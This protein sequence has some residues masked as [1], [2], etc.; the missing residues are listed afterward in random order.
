L[1]VKQPQQGINWVIAAEYQDEIDK[2]PTVG[3]WVR[4]RQ[5]DGA[6]GRVPKTFIPVFGR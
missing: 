6:A 1:H 4:K 2:K 3:T 5:L